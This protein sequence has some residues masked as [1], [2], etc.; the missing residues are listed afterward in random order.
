M[1]SSPSTCL[2]RSTVSRLR[3]R[4][5]FGSAMIGISPD[6]SRV[7]ALMTPGWFSMR[8]N[9]LPPTGGGI[10]GILGGGGGAEAP[11]LLPMKTTAV[12]PSRVL[13][14]ARIRSGLS[15]FSPYFF[16]SSGFSMKSAGEVAARPVRARTI[17]FTPVN[18]SGAAAG[19]PSASASP[20]PAGASNFHGPVAERD[21]ASSFF[22]LGSES[23]TE[24]MSSP[25]ARLSPGKIVLRR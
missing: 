19:S 2:P 21:R 25:S 7:L 24:A 14:S 17:G 10:P 11:S 18:L 9:T 15:G 12:C 4:S 1:M 20:Q 16:R 13:S 6:R 22:L 8:T 3:S 5:G 23:F